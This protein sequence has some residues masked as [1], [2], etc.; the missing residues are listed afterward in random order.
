[1][2]GEGCP[3]E[4]WLDPMALTMWVAMAATASGDA[5]CS[6]S[7][8]SGGNKHLTFEVLGERAIDDGWPLIIGLQELNNKDPNPKGV[9]GC[10]I[11]I[12][13]RMDHE[14]RTQKSI[15]PFLIFWTLDP[16]NL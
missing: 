7:S 16:V 15:Q 9:F 11:L 8:S 4:L 3:L 10:K 1:M 6:M 12:F 2:G 14:W 5:G 13:V